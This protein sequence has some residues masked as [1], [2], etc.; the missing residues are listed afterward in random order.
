M[1]DYDIYGDLNDIEEE[2]K[3]LNCSARITSLLTSVRNAMIPFFAGD[4]TLYE[5][6]NEFQRVPKRTTFASFILEC[7]WNKLRTS[8]RLAIRHLVELENMTV[9]EIGI[10]IE[11][12]EIGVVMVIGI[13]IVNVNAIETMIE[14]RIVKD[15]ENLIVA[16]NDIAIERMSHIDSKRVNE[17]DTERKTTVTIIEPIINDTTIV[18]AA[19][20]S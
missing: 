1:D 12:V 9:T 7:R 6:W 5:K 8:L 11:T 16:W 3:K 13:V 15:I 17:I 10:A 18:T 14:E 2:A 20:G 19:A 4:T